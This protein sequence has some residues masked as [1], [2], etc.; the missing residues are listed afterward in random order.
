MKDETGCLPAEASV[1]GV[2]P[3]KAYCQKWA[4]LIAAQIE[5]DQ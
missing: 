2:H 3:G 5:E 1:D 4:D